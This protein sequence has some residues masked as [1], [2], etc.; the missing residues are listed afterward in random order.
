MLLAAVIMAGCGTTEVVTVERVR[1][2][3]VRQNRTTHDS[4]FVRDS[5]H[6]RERGDTV[7]IERWHTVWQNHTAHDTTYIHKVDSVPVAYAVKEYVEKPLTRM[8]KGLIG[9]GLLS[10]IVAVFWLAGKARRLERWL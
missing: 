8:Q 9:L 7:V 6:I 3:T 1:T 10:V 4:V 5:V 2:D